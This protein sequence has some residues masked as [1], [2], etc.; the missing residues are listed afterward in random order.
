MVITSTSNAFRY[1]Y[2]WI[3]LLML[4]SFI[5]AGG[6]PAATAQE[7]DKGEKLRL[8]GRVVESLG[9]K[10]LLKAKVIV[11]D[12][13]GNLVTDTLIADGGGTVYND[14]S[15]WY[16]RAF[17]NLDVPRKKGTYLFEVLMDEY[18]PYYY[19]LTIDK[20]GRREFSRSLPEFVLTRAPRQLGEVTVVASKV[21]FYNRGDTLVFNADAF[22]L[23]EGSM[24][25]ALVK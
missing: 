17:F 6:A 22:E 5:L 16:Q 14:G 25:D 8:S 23:A 19:T 12:T 3:T 10:D 13:L 24:L 7:K 2:R 1:A 21:K 15:G 18:S 4:T 9:H 20:I 11:T